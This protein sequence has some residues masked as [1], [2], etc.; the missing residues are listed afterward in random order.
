MGLLLFGRGNYKKFPKDIIILVNLIMFLA[1]KE[2]YSEADKMVNEASNLLNE[3]RGTFDEDVDGK[4][5]E[6]HILSRGADIKL[7]VGAVDDA[8]SAA[9]EALVRYPNDAAMIRIV[10][11]ILLRAADKYSNKGELEKEAGEKLFGQV[12]VDK[13]VKPNVPD[14][15]RNKKD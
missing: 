6:A 7:Q 2:K 8:V 15:F 12:L 14:S 11:E 3:S 4:G 13:Y 10:T 9:E 1:S 5:V